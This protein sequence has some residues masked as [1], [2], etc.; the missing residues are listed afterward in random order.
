MQFLAFAARAEYGRLGEAHVGMCTP[1]ARRKRMCAKSVEKK[2]AWVSANHSKHAAQ[3]LQ[4]VSIALAV[5]PEHYWEE[6]RNSLDLRQPK[7][8]RPRSDHRSP[9]RRSHTGSA[10][11]LQRLG[12]HV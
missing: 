7:G 8:A 2:T 4:P 1:I 6:L 5:S 10:A 11:L 3:S 12:A 9:A